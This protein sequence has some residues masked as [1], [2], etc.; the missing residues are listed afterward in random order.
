VAEPEFL[1][2]SAGRTR[3]K[4][5]TP[6]DVLLLDAEC[7]QTLTCMRVYARGGLSVG[8]AATE[9]QAW[10]P[11]FR[12]T[13]CSMSATVPDYTTDPNAYVDGLLALIDRHPASMLLPAHDGS[14]EA[15]RP[16]RAEF[17]RRIGVPLASEAA[18]DIA[19]SKARTLALATE[20]GIAIPRSIRVN[21]MEDVAAALEEIGFPAVVKPDSSWVQRNGVGTRLSSSLVTSVDGA[22]R[23]LEWVFGSG[24]QALIQQWL[25]GRREA[26][27]LFYAR[28]RIWARVAQV[29][30]RE[31]PVL[32]GVSVLCE[33][34]PL[35][36]DIT[37]Q[38]ERLVRAMDLEG[39]SMV[40]FR[41]D[42]AGRPVLMEVNPRIG[43]SVALPISAG[44]N[45]P[46]LLLD[47]QLGHQL[48]EVRTYRVG[49]RLRWLAGDVWNLKCV[50]ES[51]GQPDVPKRG[52][53]A[54]DFLLD[55][56]R[57]GTDVDVLDARDM[58]PAFSEMNKIVVGHALNRVHKLLS[59]NW[60]TTREVW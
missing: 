1:K 12:S 6:I 37:E 45:F 33:T 3:S 20:L 21:R 15:I 35:L 10:A 58:R 13:S 24:G 56:I 26:V 59:N 49:R 23:D 16:R 7:R 36:S 29:S 54:A 50:F 57:P 27:S 39:C 22:K 30:H 53:A 46:Q 41:R 8:A 60:L 47:W 25:P 31:W 11:S 55:F 32:G 5:S 17:E 48:E 42:R 43:G 52:V 40:E 38:S 9:S 2:Q 34:I 51:Q 28:D 44:V 4:R 19:V 18:L 14:I